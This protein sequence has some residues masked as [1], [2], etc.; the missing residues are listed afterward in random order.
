M[1]TLLLA[2]AIAA[3]LPPTITDPAQRRA[4]QQ[5]Q[6]VVARKV[7]G[8]VSDMTVSQLRRIGRETIVKGTVSVLKRPATR[9]GELTP[10]H[11]I[12]APYSYECR[13]GRGAARVKVSPRNF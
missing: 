9:P 5:C 8:E 12:N 13:L 2:G 3:E 6:P 10:T 7:A 11:I 4:A 1:I